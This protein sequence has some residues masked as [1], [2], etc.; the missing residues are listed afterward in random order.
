MIRLIGLTENTT[1]RTELRSKHG[2]SLYIETEKHKILFDLGPNDLFLKNAEKLGIDVSAVDTA[3]ISHGHVDHCGGL[4]YFL[5]NNEKAKIFVRREATDKHFVKVLGI[6]F[7]AGI[8]K[9]LVRGDRFVFTADRFSSDE[10][11]TLFSNVRGRFPLP[12]SDGNLLAEKNGKIV[13]DDFCHEQNLL[14]SSGEKRILICGCAHAGIVNIV[15]EAKSV[16]GAYPTAVVGGFHLYE[17]VKKRYESTEYIDSVAAAL[18]ETD[19][20]FFTCHC[21]GEKAYER[22]KN[23][24]DGRLKYIRTG[25]EIV[26]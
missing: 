4:K 23:A 9:K 22:M 15:R 18:R 11:I 3:V 2:L 7:Y 5:K 1:E 26:F 13:S 24:L 25:S 16:A 10:E 20:T 17:P 21:T 14:I 12:E 19:A 6:P 8:D